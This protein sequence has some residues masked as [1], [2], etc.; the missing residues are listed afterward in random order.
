MNYNEDQY[1]NL[2]GIQHFNFCPRQ[3]ALIHVEQLWEDNSLTI[4]GQ[5]VHEKAHDE[6][7]LEKRGKVIITRNLPVYSKILGINGYCDVVE[8]HQDEDGVPLIHFDG[9]YKPIP[10]EYKKGHS[11]T[12]DADR[13]Q[14]C[15]QAMCLE[16]MLVCE[17]NIGYLY[18]DETR[19][20]E[21]VSLSQ[22]LRDQ[23]K[24]DYNMMHQYLSKGL[25]PKVRKSKKCQSCSLKEICLPGL[26]VESAKAYITRKLHEEEV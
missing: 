9:K 15:A 25:T 3:G 21:E 8:F 26:T 19:R 23:V 24:T 7:Q 1:L 17:V 11:K 16:E 20:R 2:A 22:E 12:I 5:I 18:Y 13:L 4:L 6:T 14:L 10:V